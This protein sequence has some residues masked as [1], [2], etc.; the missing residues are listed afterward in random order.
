[1]DITLTLGAFFVTFA[2]LI[3]IHELGHYTVGRLF[4]VKVLKFSIGIGKPQF[5]WTAGKDRTV[6]SIALLPLGGFVKF[7]GE[8]KTDIPESEKDRAYCNLSITKR[9]LIVLAGPLS[10]FLLAITAFSVIGFVGHT[11]LRPVIDRVDANSIA[12]HAGLQSGDEIVR[13][14]RTTTQT[15]NSARHV[16]FEK[17]LGGNTQAAILIKRKNNTYSQITL[18]LPSEKDGK[19]PLMFLSQLGIHK[20]YPDASP[21][22]EDVVP[23][24]PADLAGLMR[25]DTIVKVD[26][27]PIHSWSEI[28]T[29]VQDHPGVKL[30]FSVLRNKNV[31]NLTVKTDAID[32]DKRKIGRIGA[33]PK[34]ISGQSDLYTE[35]KYTPLAA[36]T[37]SFS[38]TYDISIFTLK[39]IGYIVTGKLAITN[40]SGPIGIAYYAGI[41]ANQGLFA[42][43][44]FIALVSISVGLLNLLPIPI[45]DGGHIV[46]YA[47]EAVRKKPLS[48]RF[49]VNYQKAGLVLVV[50]VFGIA[51]YS[52]LHRFIL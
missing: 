14:D 4:N 48:D 35:V 13:I 17:I 21:I 12:F 49:M 1:M 46:L 15:W 18:A 11:G 50:L 42:F 24:G 20:R 9:T 32:A 40:V 37:H 5:Q 2:L 8:K 7:Y 43:A 52:D 25:E 45:L 16:L 26:H 31:V 22:I 33:I 51:L 27:K 39:M 34:V 36:I 44:T 6:Y 19:V 10:N 28:A 3:T 47:A 30:Q 38:K 29:Y 41:S 23:G